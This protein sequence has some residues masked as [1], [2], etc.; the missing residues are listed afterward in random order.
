MTE[1]EHSKIE[2]SDRVSKKN[3]VVLIKET[4]DFEKI[5]NFFVENYWN[6]IWIF[7]HEKGFSEMEELKR[8]QG[9]TFDTVEEKAIDDRNT[10]LEL[11]G[12][13][14]E[15]QNEINCVNDWRYF[16]DA[17]LVRSGHSH[18][19]SQLV[20][21]P[22]HPVPGGMLNRSLGM[23]NRNNGPSSI[24][25]GMFRIFAMITFRNLAP[26]HFHSFC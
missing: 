4:N 13:I 12:K 16:Q 26:I 6:K 20:S 7:A 11:T 10:I 8:L 3:F 19:I 23:P 17:E 9:S 25:S 14:Q 22:S 21:F 5:N 24:C 2:S 15:L 1:E 18:V